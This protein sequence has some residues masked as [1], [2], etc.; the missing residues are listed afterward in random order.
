M[1][2]DLSVSQGSKTFL[3]RGFNVSTSDL[4]QKNSRFT[5]YQTNR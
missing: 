3:R 2:S 5:E 4:H 1:Y